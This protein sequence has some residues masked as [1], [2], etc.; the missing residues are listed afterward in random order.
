MSSRFKVF[1]HQ[2]VMPHRLLSAIT[3]ALMHAKWFPFRDPF[4]T[5]MIKRHHIKVDEALEPDYTD[6]SIHP[7]INSFF[8]RALRPELR[9][10]AAA[11]DAIASPVDG[12]ISQIA[13]I[14]A[15]RVIQA[16]GHTYSLQELLGGSE[17]HAATFKDGQFTTIYLSPSDY[18]RIHIP[19]TGKLTEMIHVPGK[20]LSVAPFLIEA[21]PSLFARN[22]RVVS[23]FDTDLGPMAVILVGAINVG[24]IETVWAGQI[25]PPYGKRGQVTTTTYS[26]DDNITLNKGDELGRFN[27]GSTVI[28]L[29]A[30]DKMKWLDNLTAT[31]K[32]K[33]G[34][35]IGIKTD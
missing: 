28:L 12:T 1:I 5:F 35:Q 15:D 31:D 8:V 17:K 11:A 21:V 26:D 33:M 3:Y 29:F 4:V 16:K 7:T 22:E 25:T 9:P 2:Y 18:H 23:L 10:I 34:E 6:R 19:F 14:D 13:N 27:M 24:S 30:K 20:L 32:L